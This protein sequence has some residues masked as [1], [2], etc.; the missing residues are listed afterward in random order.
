MVVGD[1]KTAAAVWREAYSA[2]MRSGSWRGGAELCGDRYRVA[3]TDA[4][5][6]QVLALAERLDYIRK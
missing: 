3:E 4:A 2:S 1:T 5:T 6:A